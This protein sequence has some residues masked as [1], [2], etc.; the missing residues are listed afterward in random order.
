MLGTILSLDEMMTQFFG[1][2]SETHRMK[3]KLI[4]EGYN[5]FVLPTK[6]GFI[7]NFTPNGRKATR[8]GEREYEKDPKMDKRLR[9]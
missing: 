3:N 6:E 2:S 7:L 1:C 9:A 8:V 5:L 4:K